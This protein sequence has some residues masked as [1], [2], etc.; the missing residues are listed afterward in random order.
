MRASGAN[1]A[2]R[3][4]LYG[5]RLGTLPLG[6]GTAVATVQ[7]LVYADWNGNGLQDAG[8]DPVAGVPL[9]IEAV[10]AGQSAKNGEFLF[11]NVPDGLHE[12]G[13]DLGALPIDFDAPAIPRL[14]MALVWA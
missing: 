7:G 3:R 13:L 11:Q 14:Q 10:G 12:V 5:E 6:S 8:E 2:D 9:R 1:P 4:G